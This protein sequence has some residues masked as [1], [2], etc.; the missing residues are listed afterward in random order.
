M[1]KNLDRLNDVFGRMV[2]TDPNG[3]DAKIKCCCC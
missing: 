3:A 1:K 2:T